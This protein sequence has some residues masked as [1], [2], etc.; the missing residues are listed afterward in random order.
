MLNHEAD[1]IVNA[2]KYERFGKR[3]GYR[4]AHYSRNFQTTAI[5]VKLVMPKLRAFRLKQSSLSNI[6][7]E[8]VKEAL[9]VMYLSGVYVHCV[10]DITK[11]LCT[12]YLTA[13]IQ[14]EK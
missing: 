1:E 3:K 10:E 7:A 5:E 2:D 13:D 6:A 14:F 8:T 12:G 9:I 11:E 4:S